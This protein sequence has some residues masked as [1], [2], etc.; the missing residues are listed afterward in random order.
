MATHL[1][2]TYYSLTYFSHHSSCRQT[3]ASSS[4]CAAQSPQRPGPARM[5]VTAAQNETNSH[6]E[7]YTLPMLAQETDVTESPRVAAMRF[8]M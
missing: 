7:S 6:D 1:I 3:A 8:A 4:S 5:H 2:L